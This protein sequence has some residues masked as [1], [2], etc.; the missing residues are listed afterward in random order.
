M[1]L[2]EAE[3]FAKAGHRNIYLANVIRKEDMKKLS[4]LAKKV[5]VLRV[6]VED[7]D[8]IIELKN[9]IS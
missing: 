2:T 1:T 8:Y 6:C 7:E 4:L 9:A 5:D 3:E